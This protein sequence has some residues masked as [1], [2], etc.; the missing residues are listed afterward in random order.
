MAVSEYVPNAHRD[1]E[2]KGQKGRSGGRR[3]R[4]EDDMKQKKRQGG[5]AKTAKEVKAHKGPA[6]GGGCPWFSANALVPGRPG[7]NLGRVRCKGGR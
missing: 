1:Y 6:G 7:A 3:P 2:S 4:K 5:N